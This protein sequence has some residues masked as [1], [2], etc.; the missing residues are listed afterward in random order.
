MERKGWP[1]S[2]SVPF[3]FVLL[4]FIFIYVLSWGVPAL[5]QQGVDLISNTPHYIELAQRQADSLL[6][7]PPFRRFP[8]NLK[9]PLQNQ[10]TH[11]AERLTEYVPAAFTNLTALVVATLSNVIWLAVTLLATYYLMLDFPKIQLGIL[12]LIPVQQRGRMQTITSEVS[13]V[14]SAYLRGLMMVCAM[15]G[16][17]VG[18]LM[19]VFRIPNPLALGFLAG[20]L[21]MVPY[22]G[23]LVTTAVVAFVTFFASTWAKTL[24]ILA[25]MLAV[26]QIYDYVIT[27]RILGGQVGLHPL[28]SLFALVTAGTLFGIVGVILSVPVAASI[29]VILRNLYPRL[30]RPLPSAD[31]LSGVATPEEGTEVVLTPDPV[32]EVEG[33]PG[34]SM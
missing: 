24:I 13:G 3:L 20:I 5:Y 15:Y 33:V 34:P 29:L 4:L 27:P 9:A 11:V 25:V 6:H 10:I 2:R 23:A 18:I 19:L 7:S 16:V 12:R 17:S 31:S 30:L 1:R 8:V 32:P 22:V 21:Y 14:F 26:H 28:V